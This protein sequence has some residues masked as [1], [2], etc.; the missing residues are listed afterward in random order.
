METL[1]SGMVT[2]TRNRDSSSVYYYLG[3]PYALVLCALTTY[4]L[5]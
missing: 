1:K 3:S 4:V 2:A 5:P